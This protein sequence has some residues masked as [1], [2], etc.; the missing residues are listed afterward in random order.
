MGGDALIL[1]DTHVLL[2]MERNDPAVGPVSRRRI[3]DALR[4]NTLAVSAVS[5]WEMAML[6]RKER[7]RVPAP[8]GQLRRDL[9]AGGLLEIPLDGETGIAAAE[10][11][12]FH[13][14]PADRM[15]VATAIRR[16]ATLMTADEQILAWPGRLSRGRVRT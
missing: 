2:W 10:L 13:A 5:F 12:G 14:D 16:G 9:L 11:D 6:V 15:I 4:D 8:V 1:L 3:D 7:I